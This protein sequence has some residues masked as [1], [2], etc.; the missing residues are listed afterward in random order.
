METRQLAHRHA[1]YQMDLLLIALTAMTTIIW[2][3][4]AQLKY[5]ME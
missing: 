5:V 2:F 3:I 4:L 1:P